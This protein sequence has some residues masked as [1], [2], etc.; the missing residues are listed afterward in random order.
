MGYY[1]YINSLPTYGDVNEPYDVIVAA[2]EPYLKDLMNDPERLWI[3]YY[4][5]FICRLGETGYDKKDYIQSCEIDEL[6]IAYVIYLVFVYLP[7]GNG[8]CSHDTFQYS[9]DWHEGIIFHQMTTTASS[10][11]LTLSQIHHPE[12]RSWERRQIVISGIDEIIMKI[13]N[14]P[15]HEIL[16]ECFAGDAW[17]DPKQDPPLNPDSITREDL[18]KVIDLVRN[19]QWTPFSPFIET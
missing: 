3:Q 14:F 2:M 5:E 17:F 7:L 8:L 19:S 15:T 16:N 6:T 11:T 18:R 1:T 12:D 4:L 13:R 9:R 10:W